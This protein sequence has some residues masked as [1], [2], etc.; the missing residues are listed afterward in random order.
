MKFQYAAIYFRLKNTLVIH[1][2]KF[3]FTTLYPKMLF[4]QVGLKWA[5]WSWRKKL[6]KIHQCI[7][8]LSLLS[9][10]GKGVGLHLHKLKFCPL[11]DAFYPVWLKLFQWFWGRRQKCR[12]FMIRLHLR[13][14][15]TTKFD[16]KIS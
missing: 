10:F 12:K 3:E 1:L 14:R 7:F 2:N 11:K 6:Y 13:R 15:T 4:C 8:T 16:Q 9:P 5:H